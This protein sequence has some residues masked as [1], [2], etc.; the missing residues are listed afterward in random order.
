MKLRIASDIHLEFHKDSGTKFITELV[1]GDFDVLCLAGDVNTSSQIYKSLEYITSLVE[2]PVLFTPG[3]HEFWGKASRKTVLDD[4][5]RL[6]DIR[7]NFILLDNK[8]YEY[9]NQRFVGATLWFDHE[10]YP[11]RYDNSMNDFHKIQDLYGWIKEEA[12]E[13]ELFLSGCNSNDIVMSHYLP[14]E[15]SVHSNFKYDVI[16]RF[17]LHDVSKMIEMNQPKLWIHGHTHFSMDY[18]VGNTRVIS[19]PYGYDDYEVNDKFDIGLT[20]DI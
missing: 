14:H 4:L 7:T 8:H 9:K 13:D 2:C 10:S 16:N 19:N 1:K 3:N 12:K 18:L 5:N 11:E 20:L 17:Y 6:E 15:N